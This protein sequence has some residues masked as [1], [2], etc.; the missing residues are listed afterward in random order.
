[1]SLICSLYYYF[2]WD[3]CLKLIKVWVLICDDEI[4]AHGT[5]ILY[6]QLNFY[7]QKEIKKCVGQNA[8]VATNYS[9]PLFVVAIY[10]IATNFICCY[11]TCLPPT[12]IHCIYH[13][14]PFSSITTSIDSLHF[15]SIT[16]NN[17]SS[18]YLLLPPAN[19]CAIVTLAT[20]FVTLQDFYDAMENIA[21]WYSHLPT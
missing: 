13:L 4:Y 19:E 2:S 20:K 11:R 21:W 7:L 1:L 8:L 3:I 18:H 15:P 5:I 10:I 17:D 16:P 14:L 12:M 6:Q 9:Q